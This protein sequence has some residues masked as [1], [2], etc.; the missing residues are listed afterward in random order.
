MSE[1]FR[2]YFLLLRT[3]MAVARPISEAR[4]LILFANENSEQVLIL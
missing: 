1:E 3:K 4:P 2:Q